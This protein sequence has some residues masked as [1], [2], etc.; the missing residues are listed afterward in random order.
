MKLELIPIKKIDSYEVKNETVYDLSVEYDHSYNIE[1]VI[2][3]NSHCLTRSKTGV[4]YPQLSCNIECSDVHGLK[5]GDKKLGLIMSDGGI[6]GP[7]DVCKCFASNSDFC[8][9][10]SLFA[11]CS[12]SY[13]EW[14]YEKDL[15]TAPY[16]R[17]FN[18]VYKNSERKKYF[19]SY[20]LSS[21]LAQ[22]KH[23]TKKDYRTSEGRIVKIPHKGKLSVILNDILSGLRSCCT[24]IGAS[25]LK[26]MSKCSTFIKVNRKLNNSLISNTIGE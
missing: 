16:I 15:S 6:R 7:D 2:V 19:I 12:E 10:G 14:E 21:S 17:D 8:M 3:H 13:G 26:D 9:I 22:E 5:S 18:V 4:G 11:G 20:G 25:S 23:F 24:Y 1:G